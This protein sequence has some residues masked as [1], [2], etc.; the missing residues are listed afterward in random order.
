MSIIEK[1]KIIDRRLLTDNRGWFLKVIDGNE[2]ALPKFTGE[3]YV[4][5]AKIG[6]AKGG[7]YHIKA[8]EWFTLITGKCDLILIDINTNEKCLLKL[9]SECPQT[10]FVPSGI[11]HLFVNKGVTE[12][13][14]IAY[15]DQLYNPSDT[16]PFDFKD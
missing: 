2:D 11:A 3:I 9:S 1:I 10:I 15:T 6:E 8:S 12:F 4:T 7:H 13:I 5:N 16:V 14:L